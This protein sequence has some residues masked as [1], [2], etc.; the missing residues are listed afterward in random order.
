MPARDLYIEYNDI[1]KL[2]NFPMLKCVKNVDTLC[3]WGQA[4]NVIQKQE[5][6]IRPVIRL[7]QIRST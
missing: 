4:R 2:L 6:I 1:T 7:K 3:K 5:K